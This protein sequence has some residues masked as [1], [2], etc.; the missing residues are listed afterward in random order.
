[1]ARYGLGVAVVMVLFVFPATAK[2]QV[3]WQPGYMNFAGRC[4]QR[5]ANQSSDATV[6]G[7]F[8]KA[9][10]FAYTS[11]N[12]YANWDFSNGYYYAQRAYNQSQAAQLAGA[13]GTA[14]ANAQAGDSDVE[15]VLN[16]P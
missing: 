12:Y 6:K 11:A 9:S 1:M 13:S 15:V 14:L 7:H 8:S 5:A 4:Y 10:N 16:N 2:A 3:P